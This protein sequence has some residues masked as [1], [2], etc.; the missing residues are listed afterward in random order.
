MLT[1]IKIS[2][3]YKVL[4]GSTEWLRSQ[5]EKSKFRFSSTTGN[6]P[7]VVWDFYKPG[8]DGELVRSH[9]K[10][11]AYID[12]GREDPYFWVSF[13]DNCRIAVPSASTHAEE[14]CI[15]NYLTPFATRHCQS[16]INKLASELIKKV[17]AD[18]QELEITVSVE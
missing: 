2:G 8:D 3:N 16:L 5:I 7:C 17:N 13:R 12:S 10:I 11:V 9:S 14:P 4:A 1:K 15:F 18:R 6:E